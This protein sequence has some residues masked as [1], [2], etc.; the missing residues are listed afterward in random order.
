MSKYADLCE[1]LRDHWDTQRKFGEGEDN[2]CV[3]LGN[4]AAAAITQLERE[5]DAA[6]KAMG[7]TAAKLGYMEAERDAALAAAGVTP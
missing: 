5:R 6:I 3:E 1:R 2:C 4:E 7:E